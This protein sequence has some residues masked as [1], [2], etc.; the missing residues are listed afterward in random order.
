MNRKHIHIRYH[1]T[2]IP[3]LALILEEYHKSPKTVIYN[4]YEL[5]DM[6]KFTH[7]RLT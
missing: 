2:I 5:I 1:R 4:I 3:F 6:K 7:S